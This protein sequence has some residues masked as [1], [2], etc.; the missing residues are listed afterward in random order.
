MIKFRKSFF[1]CHVSTK[2]RGVSNNEKVRNGKGIMRV[3]AEWGKY[4]F[5]FSCMSG[6]SVRQKYASQYSCEIEMRKLLM[7][8][9]KLKS[10]HTS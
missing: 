10:L 3:A 8:N 1:H 6:D 2:K 4:V 5:A 9:D 7:F